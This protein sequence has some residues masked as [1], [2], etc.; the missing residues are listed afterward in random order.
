MW[1]IY[2]IVFHTF[3]SSFAIQ[4]GLWSV[5]NFI[6]NYS[7]L[8]HHDDSPDFFKLQNNGK[9]EYCGLNAS[10]EHVDILDSYLVIAFCIYETP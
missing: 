1:D 4:F 10:I 8:F 7:I 3:I 2:S 9:G 5:D 6:N